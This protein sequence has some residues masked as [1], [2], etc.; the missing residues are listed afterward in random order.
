LVLRASY[1]Q[2]TSEVLDALDTAR[3]EYL[4]PDGTEVVDAIHFARAVQQL[5]MGFYYVWEWPG[6]P[7]Q[8]WLLA[9]RQWWAACRAYLKTYAREG[10]DSPFLVEE[11]VRKEGRPGSLVQAL[12]IW[13]AQRHKPPPPTRPI[14]MDYGPTAWAV[15]WA[16]RR[17]RC[18]LW[19]R[20]RAVGDLLG[21]FG[22]PKFGMGDGKPKPKQHPRAALSIAVHH[23]GRNYQE[24]SDQLVLEVPSSGAWWEQLLGRTHRYGQT[25]EEVGC[26]VFQ[27]T[28]PQRG[29]FQT[30]YE[31]SIYIQELT[32]QPQKL[33][34]SEKEGFIKHGGAFGERVEDPEEPDTS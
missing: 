2:V 17:Q 29:A 28:W 21:E 18:F 3:N 4:L 19:W 34:L 22:I 20:S 11:H 5:S 6:E 24:W 7:D 9:R 23:K 14:W 15:E 25:A 31:R 33:I 12:A 32:G 27:R 16:L 8:D 26:T 13:D 10:C 1:P 30:A